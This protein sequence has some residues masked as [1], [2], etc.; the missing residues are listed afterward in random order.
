[1]DEDLVVLGSAGEADQAVASNKETKGSQEALR[2]PFRMRKKIVE[3]GNEMEKVKESA[4]LMKMGMR[5][6]SRVTTVAC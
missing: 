6:S 3:V 2:N 4:A 5:E 1:M